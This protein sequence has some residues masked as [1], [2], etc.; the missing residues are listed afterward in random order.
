LRREIIVHPLI[1]IIRPINCI[2]MGIATFVGAFISL[3]SI[4]SITALYKLM[5]TFITAFTLTGASMVINDYFDRE[6]DKVNDPTRPIPSGEISPGGALIYAAILSVIG[7]FS[8]ALLGTRCLIVALIALAIAIAYNSYCKKY[9]IIGNL[10]VSFCVVVPFIYG[11]LALGSLRA[12]LI[13]FIS[14]VFLT[15]TG[16]EVMKG[17]VDI[18]G[19]KKHGIATIA[20]RYGPKSAAILTL[21]LFLMAVALSI[22]PPLFKLTSWPYIPLV[23]ITDIGLIYSAISVMKKSSK[24]VAIR[25]KKRVLIWMLIGLIAFMLGSIRL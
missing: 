2:M 22:L 21:I 8:A 7:L 19:D 18:E 20:V 23:L 16:R 25:E 1:R 15:N 13:L 4:P 5:L 6:I 14:M 11:G 3:G 9:G 10:M 17:I 24:E 12:Y